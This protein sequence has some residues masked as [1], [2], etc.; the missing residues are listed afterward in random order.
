MSSLFSRIISREIPAYVVAENK[1]CI[2]FLDI[3]P[4]QKGHTLVVPKSETDR[5][6]DLPKN[7]YAQLMDF[8]YLVAEAINQTFPCNRVGMSVIGLEVPHAHVHLIPI[9]RES[10]M[11][12]TSPK[13]RLSQEEFEEI[14]AKIRIQFSSLNS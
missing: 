8:A 14:A 6:F 3:F 4:L 9:N 7:E 11:N 13:L 2:A 10:D 1:S 5:L 12:F